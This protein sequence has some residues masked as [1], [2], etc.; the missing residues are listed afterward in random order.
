[1]DL[2]GWKSVVTDMCARWENAPEFASQALESGFELSAEDR[3]WAGIALFK[4]AQRIF[5]RRAYPSKMPLCS[6]RMGPIVDGVTRCWHLEHT[7]GADAVFTLPPAF[8]EEFIQGYR[9]PRFDS[10]I[11]DQVPADVMT[12]VRKAPYFRD[13]Y[14]LGGIAVEKFNDIP[15]L[16]STAGEFA[17]AT[18][19][20]VTF[21]RDQVPSA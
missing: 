9:S 17:K 15:S 14:D 18:E 5:R 1:V 21:V 7:A 3:R 10:R 4:E 12:R 20:M 8:L 11:W 2:T 19:A 13:G 6:L 16:R